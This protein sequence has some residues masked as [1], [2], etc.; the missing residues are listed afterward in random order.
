MKWIE[1][2]GL[3]KAKEIIHWQLKIVAKKQ[4]KIEEMKRILYNDQQE[5]DKRK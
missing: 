1:G 5:R 4:R 2:L 3:E